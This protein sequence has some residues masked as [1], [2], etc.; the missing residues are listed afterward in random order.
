MQVLNPDRVP[1]DLEYLENLAVS[2]EIALCSLYEGLAMNFP[3]LRPELTRI[4]G[5]HRA[6]IKRATDELKARHELRRP[7]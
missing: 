2:T 4:W 5:L 3:Y 7:D 1:A 6:E